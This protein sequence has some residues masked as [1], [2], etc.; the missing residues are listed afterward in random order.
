MQD[1]LSYSESGSRNRWSVLVWTFFAYLYDSIDLVILALCM[2]LIIKTLNLTLTQSGLLSSATM[3]GAAIGSILFGWIADNYG[4]K[5]TSVWALVEFGLFTGCI[6]FVHSWGVFMLVRFVTGLG[7]GGIWGPCVA[8]IGRH[9]APKF[10]GRASSFVL[11]GFALSNILASLLGA[12]L[13]SRYDW[14]IMFLFGA[15]AI[16]VAIFFQIFVP[17]D[18]KGEEVAKTGETV[19]IR[20]L[21][22][23]GLRKNTILALLVSCCYMGGYWGV[24]AWIPTFLVKVRGLSMS[25]MALWNMTIYFGM[26]VGYQI[27][28]Y[29]ADKFG[30]KPVLFFSYLISAILIPLYLFVPNV[31]VLLWVGPFMS[32]GFGGCTG[33][34]GA[35][36]TELFPVRMR[37]LAGGFIYNVG[38]IGS[39]IAPYTIAVYAVK[40]GLGSGIDI[41]AIIFLCGAICMLFLPETLNSKE[42]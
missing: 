38:R 25:H 18:R 11:S 15:T 20:E 27:T 4:L 39:I 35:F 34:S 9:W 3:A 36:Y 30:R 42:A 31:N 29:L 7:V 12:F 5:K 24:G 14:R 6:Y 13:L 1:Q 32:L 23:K 41:A 2:P 10:R 8:L 22:S 26:F 21:F 16:I 37:A 28:G 17:D 40:H 33:V 19:K